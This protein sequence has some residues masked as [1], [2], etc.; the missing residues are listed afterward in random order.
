LA[1]IDRYVQILTLNLKTDLYKN[2]TLLSHVVIYISGSHSGEDFDVL[3]F[4]PCGLADFLSSHG[5]TTQNA[6]NG[7]GTI[8]YAASVM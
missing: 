2:I 5:I 7:K 4:T 3:G 6:D 8:I 1:K